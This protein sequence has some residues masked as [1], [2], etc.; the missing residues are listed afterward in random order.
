MNLTTITPTIIASFVYA[1]ASLSGRGQVVFTSTASTN[2]TAL[3]YAWMFG[4]GAVGSGV[5]ATHT[6]TQSGAYTVTL[7]ATDGCGYQQ[8]PTVINAITV[9][10]YR[11]TLPLILR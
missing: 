3:T 6:Y 10:R 8:A 9:Q 11:V 7:T 5:L 2:G 4:D 1:P